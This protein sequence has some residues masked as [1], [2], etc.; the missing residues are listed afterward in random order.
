M[1]GQKVLKTHEFIT[2][3]LVFHQ[4]HPLNKPSGFNRAITLGKT[5]CL[6]EMDAF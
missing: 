4:S 3:V 6:G 5:S 2:W 1:F